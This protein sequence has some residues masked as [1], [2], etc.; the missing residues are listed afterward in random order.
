M[1]IRDRTYTTLIDFASDL[2]APT[3]TAA[4]ELAVPVRLELLAT[5]DALA[6]RQ[7]C[8]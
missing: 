6:A 5:L 7:R 8:V 4:A 1:C 3:P 2:R